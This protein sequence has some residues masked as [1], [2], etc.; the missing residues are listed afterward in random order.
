MNRTHWAVKDA[1]FLQVLR[2]AGLLDGGGLEP[3]YAF[4][5]QTVINACDILRTL[6]HTGFDRFLLELGVDGMNAGRD[7]GSLLARSNALAKFVL[8]HKEILTAEGEPID[9]AV[10]RKAAQSDPHYPN[11]GLYEVDDENRAGFWHGLQRDGYAFQDG[12][13]VAVSE[14]PA[15][16]VPPY[17]EPRPT[18]KQA[19]AVSVLESASVRLSS[20][21]RTNKVFLVHGRD[22]GAMHEVARYLERLGLEVVILHERPNGGRTLISKFREES[23]DIGFAIVLMTPDDVGHLKDEGQPAL[24]ARQN[25]VFELGFFIG[26]LGPERVCALVAGHLEKPSDFEAVIYVTFGPNTGWRTEVA[27]ELRAAGI[28]FDHSRVF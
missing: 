22:Q 17:A 23:A 13:I 8:N 16:A 2:T 7:R 26:K 1:D 21:P 11:G 27:R 18:P 9:L 15:T 3:V 20:P 24:R 25:V 5:R 6:G 10:V 28:P 19:I 4:S 14:P 12:R